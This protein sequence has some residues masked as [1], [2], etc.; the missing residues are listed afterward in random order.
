VAPVNAPDQLPGRQEQL[1]TLARQNA[2]QFDCIRLFSETDPRRHR[3]REHR[4]R[5][6]GDLRTPSA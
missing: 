6:E 4:T 2:C 1:R 3:F 5:A